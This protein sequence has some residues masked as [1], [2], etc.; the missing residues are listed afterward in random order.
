MQPKVRRAY[1]TTHKTSP[2][3]IESQLR[4]RFVCIDAGLKALPILALRRAVVFGM[5]EVID[6]SCK[7]PFFNRTPDSIRRAAKSESSKPHP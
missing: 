5:P 1:S 7:W 6:V 3:L 2:I 4:A